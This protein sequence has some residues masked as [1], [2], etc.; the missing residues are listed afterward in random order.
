MIVNGYPELRVNGQ[1]YFVHA[2]DFPYYGVPRDL[3]SESLDRFIRLGINTVSLRIPWSW[4]EPSEGQLD[5]DGHTNPAR[6][7]RMLLKLISSKHLRL[8]IQA[9][10][11]GNPDLRGEGYP[12]WL[13]ARPEFAISPLD[14]ILGVELLPIA[15]SAEI[16]NGESSWFASLAREL[17]AAVHP[18]RPADANADRGE[19]IA[20]PLSILFIA[21]HAF[22]PLNSQTSRN[23]NAFE[24]FREAFLAARIDSRFFMIPANANDAVPWQPLPATIGIAGRWPQPAALTRDLALPPPPP[25]SEVSP[26]EIESASWLAQNLRLQPETTPS[27]AS[28]LAAFQSPDGQI[29][30]AEA[31]NDLLLSSRAFIANGVSAL[32]YSRFQ[33]GI[34]PPGYERDSSAP[35]AGASLDVS[36]NPLPPADAVRRNGD[37]IGRSGSFLASAHRRTILGIVDWRSQLNSSDDDALRTAAAQFGFAARQIE[38]VATLAD[39]PADLV[40]P[41]RQSL[42][43]LLHDTALLLIVPE[44]L[45]GRQFLSEKSQ[46]ALLEFVRRG[47][48]LICAPELPP[49]SFLSGAVKELQEVDIADAIS[50]RSLGKGKVITW[51]RDFYSWVRLNET[52]RDSRQHGEAAPAITLLRSLLLAENAR[53]PVLRSAV[54]SDSLV[55]SE[56]IPNIMEASIG[57]TRPSCHPGHRCAEGLLSL[58]NASGAAATDILRILPPITNHRTATD[59]NYV[60]LPVEVAAQESL[61]LPLDAPLCIDE[62]AGDDCEDRVVAAGAELHRVAREGKTLKLTFYAP[63]NATVLMHLAKPPRH[64]ELLE[65]SIDGKYEIDSK[66]FTFQIPRGASPDFER[67]VK[68]QMPY[69]PHVPEAAKAESAKHHNFSAAILN[70]VRLPRPSGNWLPGYPSL[71]LLDSSRNGRIVLN[72]KNP[73]D[74]WFSVKAEVTGA[75]QASKSVRVENQANNIE[76]IDLSAAGDSASPDADG[77]LH[78]A[79]H[80]SSND[81]SVEVPLRFFIART[82]AP[83]KYRFDFER[84][85]S[86]DWVI[87]ND[88]LRLII[89]PARG[90]RIESLI[91]KNPSAAVTASAGALRDYF[92]PSGAPGPLP[93]TL[94]TPFDAHWLDDSRGAGISMAA[95][96]PDGLPLAGHLEKLVRVAD[97]RKIEISYLFTPD[98]E[99]AASAADLI[100]TFS[101]PATEAAEQGTQFCWSEDAAVPTAGSGSPATQQSR[102]H[103]ESFHSNSPLAVPTDIHELQVR[104]Q[105]Q[106]TLTV[107]WPEGTLVIEQRLEFAE[108]RLAFRAS[109]EAPSHGTVSY[110]LEPGGI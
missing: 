68:L 75:V 101:I 33:L 57:E 97:H 84:S 100:T 71:L 59:E 9:G 70:D 14:R 46:Q 86:P 43:F 89:S 49:D 109:S 3:W 83:A 81:H 53:S 45:R 54:P 41:D 25:H 11:G 77:L 69:T 67:V 107:G 38:L 28:L 63:A 78:G 96:L 31:R 79:L 30:M 16:A 37:L 90:G 91:R 20:Q 23:T 94:N 82:D 80:L 29:S 27:V 39:V 99:A 72:L 52:P 17:A 10:P 42:S 19:P 40:D 105:G 12:D 76:T 64:V 47:G 51:A 8:V 26:I 92:A 34:L 95:R 56:L 98:D 32:T 85:G 35:G 74:S 18:R 108:L 110:T 61:M 62:K 21:F 93:I 88:A 48:A 50:Q 44:A 15:R 22:A 73:Q 55:F 87:E 4:H 104:T 66:I 5:F 36:A 103:C 1:P 7:L 106:L 24:S 102:F 58:A 65:R 6:D 60:A 13:L 2:A